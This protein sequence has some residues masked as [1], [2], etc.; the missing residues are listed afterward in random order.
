MSDPVRKLFTPLR[1][2]P[3]VYWLVILFALMVISSTWLWV[4]E[5]REIHARI[6]QVKSAFC[7]TA[8]EQ[9]L[10][11]AILEVPPQDATDPAVQHIIRGAAHAA[12]IV[13][14]PGVH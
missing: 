13:Q 6:S 11:P 8:Q 3:I 9:G 7:G 12:R 2:R 14:C 4:K 1:D 5:N 10:L